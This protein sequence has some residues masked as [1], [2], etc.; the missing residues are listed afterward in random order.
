M[1]I[2][3]CII[4]NSVPTGRHYYALTYASVSQVYTTAV[5]GSE[6]PK[7]EG[8]NAVEMVKQES[9]SSISAICTVC[10]DLDPSTL[11][12]A[13]NTIAIACGGSARWVKW[14]A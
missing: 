4:H 14:G 13:L 12:P 6:S 7:L 11:M 8:V 1:D 2:S 3:A 10:I 9:S 5:C